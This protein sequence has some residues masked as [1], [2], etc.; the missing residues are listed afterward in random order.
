[1]EYNCA[2]HDGWLSGINHYINGT[3]LPDGETKTGDG[4]TDRV[5]K[6]H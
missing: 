2:S 3:G 4:S 1:M 6:Q 5:A